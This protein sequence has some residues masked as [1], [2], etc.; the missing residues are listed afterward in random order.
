MRRIYGNVEII[1]V[2]VAS[3]VSHTPLTDEECAEG[4]DFK[5]LMTYIHHF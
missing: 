2:D 5:N 3:N 1:S 4:A